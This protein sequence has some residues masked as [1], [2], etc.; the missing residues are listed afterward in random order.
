VDV[1]K[2]YCNIGS[3][4]LQQGELE[5]ALEM[6][7]KDLKITRNALGDGHVS[8]ADTK[9]NIGLVYG[10]LGDEA[11]Q[12]QLDR[13]AHSIY[14]QALGPDLPKTKEIARFI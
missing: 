8:V 10:K 13:E 12:L 1:V 6:F 9:Q 4:Y 5:R 2:T 7:E 3:V 11:K 14:L